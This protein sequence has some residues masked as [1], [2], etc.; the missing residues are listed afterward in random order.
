MK[1]LTNEEF[2]K[3]AKD[4]HGD[5]YDY[6]KIEYVNNKTKVCIICPEHGCFFMKPNAHINGKQGC[7]KCGYK[8]LSDKK[9][10]STNEF[11]EKARNIHGDKYDYS[12]VDYTNTD[13]KV[14]IIC[15]KH[16]V[17]LQR[18]HNHL[19]GQG[20]PKCYGNA[21]VNKED[22]VNKSNLI[23]KNKY[24]YS[25]VEYKNMRSFVKIICPIHGEFVQK[26]NDHIHGHGCPRCYHSKLEEEIRN[27]LIKNKIVFE[28]QKTFD[29]LKHKRKLRFDFYL[30][31]YKIAIE[32]QGEQHYVYINF[33]GEIKSSKL[34][35]IVKRDNIKLEFCNKNDILLLYYSTYKNKKY[36]DKIITS[37][38]ILKEKIL[39]HGKI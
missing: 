21:V 15:P 8:L 14:S 36:D 2:I 28:E 26:A 20:C 39:N 25:K 38:K 30:P 11:I 22:F 1:K 23:H 9:R 19:K 12:Y 7:P 31:E 16:G 13:K 4:V 5:K 29:G 24:D 32:C 10:M 37:K 34:E 18:P 6:S 17:F 3:L 35:E 27:F 33:G